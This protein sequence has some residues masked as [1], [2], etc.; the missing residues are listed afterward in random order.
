MKT[1]NKLKRFLAILLTCAMVTQTTGFSV[2]AEEI[3]TEA[4]TEQQTEIQTEA[5]ETQAAEV[6]Q[7]ETQA[8]QSESQTATETEQSESQTA[9][10]AEQSESQTL[11]EAEQ[12]EAQTATEA[13]QSESQTVT[14]AEQSE[15]QTVAETEQSESQ[16][17]TETQQSE[18]QTATEAEQSEAQQ[19]E[20][21]A[22]ARL[23]T[24]RAMWPTT[25]DETQN[26]NNLLSSVAIT[27]AQMGDDNYYHVVDG[28][29]YTVTLT[30]KESYRTYQFDDDAEMIYTLPNGLAPSSNGSGNFTITV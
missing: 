26:L 18:S 25:P 14:E 7:S 1:T 19:S 21:Q 12:S 27:G 4:Q 9:T 28:T 23:S 10:E 2:L 22:S 13:E 24:A 16:A 5:P 15:S 11:T 8:V 6:E 30:F 20:T 17:A 29:S 3:Q